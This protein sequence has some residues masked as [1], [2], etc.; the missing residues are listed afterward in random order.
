MALSKITPSTLKGH[1]TA[2]PSKSMAHRALISAFLAEEK[3]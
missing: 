3:V 2:Q 1:V